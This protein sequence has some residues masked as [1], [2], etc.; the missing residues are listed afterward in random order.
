MKTLAL[1]V[2]TALLLTS[3]TLVKSIDRLVRPP[4][5]DNQ[6]YSTLVDI[7]QLA[8]H[9]EACDNPEDQLLLAQQIRNK[10]DWA[11]KYSEHIP[12]NEEST[13]MLSIL[14]GEVDKFVEHAKVKANP[15]YCKLKLENV[16]EQSIVIQ[17]A[18]GDK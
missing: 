12:R 2:L 14:R 16:V 9:K 5:F 3:C 17:K 7:R 11:V 1:A 4:K 13:Q 15:T 18:L 8:E 10:V 6:E